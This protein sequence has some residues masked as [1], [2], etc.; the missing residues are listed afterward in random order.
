METIT[1][2]PRP[3]TRIAVGIDPGVRTGYAYVLWLGGEINSVFSTTLNGRTPSTLSAELLC[4]IDV[5]HDSV[6]HDAFLVAVEGWAWFGGSP[7]RTR[8]LAAAAYASG[9][10]AG[11][12]EAYRRKSQGRVDVTCNLTRPEILKSLG[13][14]ANAS[15][16][17]LRQ[18][19]RAIL[20][21]RVQKM[22]DGASEHAYDAVAVA[23]AADARLAFPRFPAAKPWRGTKR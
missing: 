21:A 14:P 22:L 10:V 8:G 16:A 18:R 1:T 19:V 12:V 20:P 11:L 4:Q 13:L 15:K 3:L 9:L 7:E 6:Q 23:L 17:V 5:V 2:I